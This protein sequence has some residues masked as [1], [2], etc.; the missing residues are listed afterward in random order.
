MHRNYQKIDRR[1]TR[2]VN[3]GNVSIGGSN[4]ISV[5]TMTTTLTK[6]VKATIKQISRVVKSGADLVRVSIPD[7]D[8]S[9]AL[10][11]I[12]KESDVP[13]IADIHFHYKR[14]LE[15]ADNGAACLRINPGNIGSI[16]KIKE[17]IKAAKNNKMFL[18]LNFS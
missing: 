14:A 2:V 11:F 12:C 17:V 6:D 7:E 9:H 5:Q 13:V 16:E 3:V 15:A 4:P 8:S 1:L 18:L 10:K